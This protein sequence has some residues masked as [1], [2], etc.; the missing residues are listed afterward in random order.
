M[1]FER[2]YTKFT[3]VLC[4]NTNALCVILHYVLQESCKPIFNSRL[5]YNYTHFTK[6]KATR[7]FRTSS[8]LRIP[9]IVSNVTGKISPVVTKRMYREQTVRELHYNYTC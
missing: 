4:I 8:L 6:R 1:R 5:T 3:I 2:N 7:T 9:D